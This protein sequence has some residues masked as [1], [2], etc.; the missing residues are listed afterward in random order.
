MIGSLQH[1]HEA[2]RALC[3]PTAHRGPENALSSCSFEDRLVG[4]DEEMDPARQHS[5]R[6]AVLATGITGQCHLAVVRR[7][8]RP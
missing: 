8:T 2:F 6:R 5:N 3:D 4:R 7:V 1:R